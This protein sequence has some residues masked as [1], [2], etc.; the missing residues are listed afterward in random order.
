[1]PSV[2]GTCQHQWMDDV[3]V[4]RFPAYRDW[5]E[6]RVEA[7]NAMMGLLAGAQ[8][9]AHLLKLTAGSSHLLPEVF[10][11]V[12]HIGRFNLTTEEA[13]QILA[14]ADT[15]LGAMSIPYALALHE[16]Y[17][18][19][20]LR[21]LC[22]AGLCPRSAA[23][24]SLAKQ[25]SKIAAVTG[26]TFDADRLAQLDTLRV[27][28]NCMIHEGGRASAALVTQV[29]DWTARTEQ[30]WL[31]VAPSLRGIREGEQVPFGHQ[32]LILT[33]AVTKFLSRQAN[34]LIQRVVP[35]DLWAD[36]VVEDVVAQNGGALPLI[37]ERM[38]KVRGVARFDYSALHLQESE[39]KAALGRL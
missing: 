1:M 16:D 31:K 7:S 22:R 11:Q 37:P 9:A 38:R 10:P 24:L 8:L 13:S 35:R 26:R 36:I 32:Q 27:M 39:L 25:H 29:A 30:L 18:K 2:R 20:C 34:V 5:D 12:G 28:R 33:L 17:L 15:H 4:V 23:D 3:R 19:S 14:A 21:L 6:K